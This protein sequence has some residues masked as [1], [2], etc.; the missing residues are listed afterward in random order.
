MTQSLIL[1][2]LFMAVLACLPFAIKWLKQRSLVGNAHVGEQSK[3]ISAVAVGPNQSVVTIEAGPE[4][5]RV[6]LTI[7]V[8]PTSIT[9][10]HVAPIGATD[11]SDR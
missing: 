6:W 4:H 10:L 7:G 9:C 8:T 1:I 3:F 11:S 2:G 5:A